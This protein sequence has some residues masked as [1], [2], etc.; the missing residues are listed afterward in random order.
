MCRN[1][2]LKNSYLYRESLTSSLD[3]LKTKLISIGCKRVD[4]IVW[5]CLSQEQREELESE[6]TRSSPYY[7]IFE[8]VL[9]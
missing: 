1:Q 2:H 8:I 7:Y 9:K 3:F 5:V 6:N 4:S